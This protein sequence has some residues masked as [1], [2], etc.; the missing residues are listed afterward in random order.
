[1][2]DITPFAELVP[3]L[4]V[5]SKSVEGALNR[6]VKIRWITEKPD[7]SSSILKFLQSHSKFKN[8]EVRFILSPLR[9]KMGIFDGK[10]VMLGINMDNGFAHSPALWSNNP[11]FAAIAE[12]YF[13][14]CWKRGLDLKIEK[15][16]PMKNA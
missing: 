1:M 2:N 8:F 5:L 14:S 9:A 3:W 16:N 11:S 10:E 6:G 12:N 15:I 13:E 7:N 4:T